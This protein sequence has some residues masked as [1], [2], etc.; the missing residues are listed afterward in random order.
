MIFVLGID[1]ATWTV[2]RPNLSRL[3]SFQRLCTIGKCIELVL[4]ETP[5]SPSV[6]C[7]MF[8]GKMPGEHG[9]HSYVVNGNIVK[10]EDIKVDFIWDVLDR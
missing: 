1:A 9:H 8:S 5:I 10:R 4:R 6:W 2:V 3:K 7:S